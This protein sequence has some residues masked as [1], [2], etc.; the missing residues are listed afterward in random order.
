MWFR[1]FHT[2]STG[3]K[4]YISFDITSS[5]LHT[6]IGTIDISAL[7]GSITPTTLSEP[8]NPQYQGL[9][10]SSDGVWITYDSKNL[11]WPPLEYRSSCSAVLGK[12]IGIGV[13][14]GRVL[15]YT[16]FSLTHPKA[17]ERL[18]R[19]NLLS[20]SV[21][22]SLF[23][24]GARDDSLDQLTRWLLIEPHTEDL[25]LASR[26]KPTNAS[27]TLAEGISKSLVRLTD[28]LGLRSSV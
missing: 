6:E 14:T 25:P 17:L 8:C 19:D 28:T 4:L 9:A 20:L 16:K 26:Q 10:L 7:S 2:L 27:I 12:T 13:R 3:K 24:G 21:L 15:I 18:C 1:C 11:M 5:Y 22:L 23:H